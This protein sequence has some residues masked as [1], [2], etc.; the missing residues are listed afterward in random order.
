MAVACRDMRFGRPGN[1]NP[2]CE[3]SNDRLRPRPLPGLRPRPLLRTGKGCIPVSPYT[4][5]CLINFVQSATFMCA[6]LQARLFTRVLTGAVVPPPLEEQRE[7]VEAVRMTLAARY[8]DRQQLRS[9]HGIAFQ[10]APHAPSSTA[11][12]CL[13]KT[14]DCRSLDNTSRD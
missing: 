3:Y 5:L 10:C 12:A 2:C 9:Q 4:G 13:P 14:R 8:I 7:E 6:E 1:D 11:A